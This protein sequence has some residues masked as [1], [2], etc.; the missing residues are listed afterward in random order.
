MARWQR[1]ELRTNIYA[2][3]LNTKR[4]GATRKEVA[5]KFGLKKSPHLTGILNDL[6]HD[7]WLYVEYEPHKNGLYTCP[8][9]AHQE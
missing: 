8:Y 1:G 4:G 3:L 7:N 6:I 5:E 2:W 9:F